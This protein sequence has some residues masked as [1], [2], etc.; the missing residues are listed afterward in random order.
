MDRSSYTLPLLYLVS[1]ILFIGCASF[2]KR[3]VIDQSPIIL[4]ISSING[5]YELEPIYSG[6]TKD[7]ARTWNLTSSDL[8]VYHTFYDELNNGWLTKKIIVDPSKR[9]SFTI[10]VI[11][12]KKLAIDYLEGDSIIR[13]KKIRFGIR[14]D[15]YLYLKNRSFKMRGIPYLFGDIDK[16][17]IRLTLNRDN[18]LLF[19]TAEFHS[20]GLFL[21]MINPFTKMKYEKIF[22]RIE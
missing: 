7:T 17:R 16:K 20:G 12:N 3:S 8:G 9:Y 4:K 19:E 21:L 6:P 11:D 14:N 1:S 22:L 13:Q 18:N 10:E 2:P 15:G 5:R